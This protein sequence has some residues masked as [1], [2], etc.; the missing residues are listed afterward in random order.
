MELEC[1]GNIRNV[2]I[3]V[4]KPPTHVKSDTTCHKV[5]VVL[6]A[7]MRVASVNADIQ[8]CKIVLLV[9]VMFGGA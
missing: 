5:D 1:G 4:P 3:L 7:L 6:R 8:T 2:R 9:H